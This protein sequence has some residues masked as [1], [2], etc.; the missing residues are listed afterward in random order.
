MSSI[1]KALRKVE[2]E[3][4]AIGEGS[5]DLAHDILKRN[6]ATKGTF[7]W[8]VILS[9]I[10]FL[11]FL[12]AASWWYLQDNQELLPSVVE[13]VH[14]VV[15]TEPVLPPTQPV[16]AEYHPPEKQVVVTSAPDAEPAIVDRPST[17]ATTLSVDIPALQIE[18]IV[19]HQQASLRLAVVNG[20][21]VMEGTDIE[22]ARIE[23]IFPDRVQFYFQGIRFN[24]FK[25]AHN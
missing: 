25:T 2:D 23:K 24:K 9:W 21:P 3:K 22:G 4:A 16:A 11:L 12:L 18:E 10:I 14:P 8:A 7:P 6:F 17:A 5:V 19:F 13:T 20:L 1:L 15:Q